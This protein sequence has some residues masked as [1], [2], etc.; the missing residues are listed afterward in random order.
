MLTAAWAVVAIA[1]A[2][3]SAALRLMRILLIVRLNPDSL[4]GS[5]AQTLLDGSRVA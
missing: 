2:T 5:V 3:P 1:S 4:P